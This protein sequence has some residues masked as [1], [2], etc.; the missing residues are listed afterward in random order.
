M[1]PA[2]FE[3]ATSSLSGTRSNQLSY[4]PAGGG[5]YEP[6][7]SCQFGARRT[8]HQDPKDTKRTKP[9]SDFLL[10]LMP[11]VVQFR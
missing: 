10:S 2:E 5:L 7:Q 4:E 8:N 3:S 11:L 1:G 6:R 9:I